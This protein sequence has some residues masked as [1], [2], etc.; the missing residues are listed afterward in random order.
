MTQQK[1][2]WTI[3]TPKGELY[4]FLAGDH[5]AAWFQFA[6]RS[7]SGWKDGNNILFFATEKMKEGYKAVKLVRASDE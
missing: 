6:S 3:E 4:Q 1:E 2:Y 7:D 5:V